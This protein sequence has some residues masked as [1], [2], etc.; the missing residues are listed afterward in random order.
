MT[1]FLSTWL[2]V[3]LARSDLWH[4]T[5][6]LEKSTKS[7]FW[8]APLKAMGHELG[9]QT[10]VKTSNFHA[11]LDEF[12]ST[13][14]SKPC[15]PLCTTQKETCCKNVRLSFIVLSVTCTVDKNFPKNVSSLPMANVVGVYF[16]DWQK[17]ETFLMNCKHCGIFV[18]SSDHL[19][20]Y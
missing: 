9:V 17:Y 2:W 11:T 18:T 1:E 14:L 13:P 19:P 4:E 16:K 6:L 20:N 15:N 7:P 10:V 8:W 3:A 5:N 12:I